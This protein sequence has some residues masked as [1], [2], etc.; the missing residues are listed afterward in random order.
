MMAKPELCSDNSRP[1][2]STT[3]HLVEGWLV[4]GSQGVPNENVTTTVN[5]ESFQNTTGPNGYFNLTLN[6]QPECTNGTYQNTTYTITA[7]FAGDQ[8]LNATAY[9]NTLDGEQYP[10]CTTVQNGYEPSSNSTVLTVTPQSTQAMVP[11]ETPDQL[12]Q[13]AQSSGWFRV[14]NEFSWWYPW[15]R[16]HFVL[17]APVQPYGTAYADLGW[18]L[19]P[20]GTTFKANY[21]VFALMLGDVS[22]NIAETL[23][24]SVIVANLVQEAA[25]GYAGRTLAGIALAVGAYVAVNIALTAGMLAATGGTQA[26]YLAAFLVDAFSCFLSFLIDGLNNVVQLLTAAYQ[27][28]TGAITC[29][30]NSAWARGLD[31]FNITQVAFNFVDFGLMIYDLTMYA[32]LA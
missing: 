1:D 16:L 27:W 25:S 6:L 23:F 21:T 26:S 31:F 12:K 19:L 2:K 7:S 14:Y 10:E 20:F 18:S 4:C 13:S 28:I 5:G 15:Y 32:N 29:A 17:N 3:A 30:L 9:D 8:P 24:V 11:T 22:E